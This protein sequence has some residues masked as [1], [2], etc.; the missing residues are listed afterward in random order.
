MKFAKSSVIALLAPAVA[1]RFVESTEGDKVQL[2]PMGYYETSSEQ[3]LIETSA[4]VTQW[5]T[6]DEKWAL[7]R[8]CPFHS[9]YPDA[10]K[11]YP[12]TD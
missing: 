1:G 3:Y 5:V 2:Y 7:K 4:G 10:V 11:H 12:G 8:V 6:E 9:P